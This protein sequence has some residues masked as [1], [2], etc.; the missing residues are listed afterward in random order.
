MFASTRQRWH[1]CGASS[2]SFPHHTT[3]SSMP[4]TPLT[5]SQRSSLLAEALLGPSPPPTGIPSLTSTETA[6]DGSYSPYSHFRVGA[7]L[8]AE[9]GTFVRG[10]NVENASY[11]A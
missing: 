3:L 1:A 10:A 7:C 9:D 11:G 8:L 4:S 6:R 2:S 5:P